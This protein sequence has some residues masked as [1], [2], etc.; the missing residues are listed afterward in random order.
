MIGEFELK[1]FQMAKE[2][3]PKDTLNLVLNGMTLN[4]LGGGSSA[5]KYSGAVV[6]YLDALEF[7]T[8]R[9]DDAKGFIGEKTYDSIVALAN[10]MFNG[11]LNEAVFNTTYDEVND[12]KPNMRTNVRYLQSIGGV[13]LVS[14]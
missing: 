9:Y 13:S 5:I 3:A 1:A 8:P 7:G 11:T 14:K 6:P 4:D 12:Y 10:S 2:I